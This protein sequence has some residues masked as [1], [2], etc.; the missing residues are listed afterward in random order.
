MRRFVAAAVLVIHEERALVLRRR[1]DDRSFAHRW[2]VPGGGMEPRD[3]SIEE[4]ARREAREEAGLEV[5]LER[6]LG[7]REVRAPDR[8]LLFRIHMFVASSAHADVRLGDEHVAYRWLDRAA[9]ADA[10]ATLP[11]GLAGEATCELLAR[12]ARGELPAPW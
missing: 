8:A 1:P 7:V 4:T 12:F 3:A 10:D 2:C 9:A 11:G 5:A 6:A